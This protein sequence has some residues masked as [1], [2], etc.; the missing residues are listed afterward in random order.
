MTTAHHQTEARSIGT[1]GWVLACI[2]LLVMLLPVGISRLAP[3]PAD[4]FR[5]LTADAHVLSAE[6][7]SHT[8]TVGP[9]GTL[10]LPDSWNLTRRGFGGTIEYRLQTIDNLSPSQAAIFIPRVKTY[11]EIVVQGKTVFSETDIA[12]GRGSNR[13]VFVEL[14][15]HQLKEGPLDIVIRVRGYPNDG[16]GLSEVYIGPTTA[17]RPSYLGRWLVQDELLRLSNWIVLAMCVPFVLLW[18]RDPANSQSYGLFAAGALVF[19]ARSFHR[20]VDLQFLPSE[21]TTP[22]ISASLGWAALPLWIFLTRHVGTPL[23]RFERLMTAFTIVGTI[24]LFFIPARYYSL[25]DALAWRTP[26]FLS[27]VFCITIVVVQTIRKPSRSRIL[28]ASALI[29]QLTPALHDLLW[30]YGSVDFSATQWFP[31]SFPVLL[32]V[33][34]LVLADD[35]ATTKR[36][37]RNANSDL[38]RRISEARAELDDL[39]EKK[40]QSDAEAVMVEERHRLMRDMHDG[41]G[42]HLSLLLS[43]LN[44]GKLSAG[45]VKD[46]VQTTLDELRL[47][48]DARSA[49]TQ[50][51]VDA[52]SN[53]RDRLEPRLA[54]IGINTRWEIQDRA[55]DI[56]LSA[57]T[58]LHLLRIVQE[59]LNNAI[60]H[61][62]P[63]E[64]VFRVERLPVSDDGV[65]RGQLAIIDNGCGPTAADSSSKGNGRGLI[66]MTSRARAIGGTFKLQREQMQTIA[67]TVF[68]ISG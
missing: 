8:S 25:F 50:T 64:I 14:G 53:L 46:G 65:E 55:D 61:G 58:T 68:P 26:V 56:C 49:T 10:T 2:F 41:V 22:L 28:L 40:R 15:D 5:H 67:A 34:A 31:L 29:A 6:L 36:E 1:D 59:C 37:L 16:S 4:T 47:L 20:Q 48:I 57:E 9:A 39:Y 19:A 21:L 42:T 43:G 12:Q 54:S 30:L 17:L 35:V 23:P 13:S 66:N 51:L 60:R 11:G 45:Q 52:L 33:M 24:V 38:E 62:R 18:A 44:E 27:G 63:S 3:T 7:S 32:L